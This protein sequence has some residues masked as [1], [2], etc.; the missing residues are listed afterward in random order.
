M[1]RDGITPLVTL[2]FGGLPKSIYIITIGNRLIMLPRPIRRDSCPTKDKPIIGGFTLGQPLCT[3]ETFIE[4]IGSKMLVFGTR[5]NM[6]WF[7]IKEWILT[8][9]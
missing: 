9:R 7:V 2:Q 4:R 1:V 6:T 8:T 3:T 5:S